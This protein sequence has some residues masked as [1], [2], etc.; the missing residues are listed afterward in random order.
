MRV[1]TSPPMRMHL[2]SSPSLPP[3]AGWRGVHPE[4][5]HPEGDG[6]R[7][8]QSVAKLSTQKSVSSQKF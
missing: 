7:G 1:F 4:G 2:R 5:I 3:K 8:V 6:G